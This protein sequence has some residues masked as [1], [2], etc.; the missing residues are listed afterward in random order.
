MSYCSLENDLKR[1]LRTTK[2]KIKIGSAAT[3]HL[4]EVEAQAY[5]NDEYGKLNEGLKS[6]GYIVPFTAGYTTIKIIEQNRAA[7]K[8]YVSL[9]PSNNPDGLPDAVHQWWKEAQTLWDGIVSGATV[10][11]EKIQGVS[12]GL[13]RYD[14]PKPVFDKVGIQGIGDG[15]IED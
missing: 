14:T 11:E 7:Y 3:D 12:C 1:L 15:E 13:P 5:I 2:N 8:I 4:T 10:L 9:F 6:L